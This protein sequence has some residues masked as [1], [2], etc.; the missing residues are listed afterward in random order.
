MPILKQNKT[1]DYLH[2]GGAKKH[3]KGT[4]QA[5]ELNKIIND[6][7]ITA[8]EKYEL[9][10]MQLQRISEKVEQK[11]ENIKASN[12]YDA[13]SFEEAS[14]MYINAIQAKLSLLNSFT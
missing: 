8:L 10:Q 4:V 6:N 12:G 3:K 11:I 5:H 9:S 13:K 1:K 2:E 7:S 14:D